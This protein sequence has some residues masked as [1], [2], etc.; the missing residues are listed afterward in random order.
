MAVNSFADKLVKKVFGSSSDIFLK[1]V[2]PVVEQVNALE[3]TIE[4]LSD[5]ELKAQTPK[6]KERIKNALAEFD[7]NLEGGETDA[8][9]WRGYGLSPEAKS[10]LDRRRKAEQDILHEILPEAFATVREASRRVTGMRHFDGQ[11]FGVIALH[12][13]RIA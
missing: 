8:P 1:K 5:D 12:Q 7:K 4:K 13:G 6:L 9:V 10:L 2:R 3:P 11:L